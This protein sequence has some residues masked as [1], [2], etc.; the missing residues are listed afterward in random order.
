M[1]IKKGLFIALICQVA[2]GIGLF[3]QTVDANPPQQLILDD[4]VLGVAGPSD[5]F[6][7]SVSVDG[8]VA[9]VG[10]SKTKYMGVVYIYEYIDSTWQ[11]THLIEAPDATPDDLFGAAVK[12]SGD[13]LVV[14]SQRSDLLSSTGSVYVYRHLNGEWVFTQKIKS[15]AP[16]Y[17]AQ[18]GISVET[19]GDWLF[20]GASGAH[21]FTKDTAD[22]GAAY[23]YQWN[24][25]N[26]T[27]QQTIQPSGLEWESFFGVNIKAWNN[28][29]FITATGEDGDMG[30]VYVYD[31][32]A[33]TLAFNQKLEPTTPSGGFFG[34]SMAIDD[35]FLLI[36]APRGQFS[37]GG[38]VYAFTQVGGQ[39][40]L[41][42][43]FS[44]ADT[45][46]SDWFGS[47][48]ALNNGE[49]MVGAYRHESTATDS[50][51]IY[52]FKWQD[53]SWQEFDK[54]SSLT[55]TPTGRFGTAIHLDDQSLLVGG[56]REDVVGERSGAVTTFTQTGG[57]WGD[58]NLL[59][60]TPGNSDA[61]LGQA[62]SHFDQILCAASHQP[63]SND[64][65]KLLCHEW[66]N[67]AWQL[68]FSMILNSQTGAGQSDRLTIDH[69]DQHLLLGAH[70]AGVV[71]VFSKLPDGWQL[72][73]T[74]SSTNPS[75]GDFGRSLAL[76]GD[77]AVI[78]TDR[79]AHVYE[80]DG[81]DWNHVTDLDTGAGNSVSGFGREVRIDNST[82]VVAGTQND[83]DTPS[84]QSVFI[85][86]LIDSTWQ[87]TQSI[88]KQLDAATLVD[89]AASIDLAGNTLAIGS[90]PNQIGS[91]STG[92]VFVFTRDPN[93]TLQTTLKPH[94]GQARHQ[95]GSHIKITDDRVLVGSP[96][97][98][99]L[100]QYLPESKVSVFARDKAQN[101]TRVLDLKTDLVN[102]YSLFG[103]TI[104]G[105]N[106]ALFVGAPHAKNQGAW[107]GAIVH[108]DLTDIDTIFSDD[109][110]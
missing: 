47:A 23:A 16:I 34:V 86:E 87:L 52:H 13:T 104:D 27:L 54:I 50:G 105:H 37:W 6:G 110:D 10:A 73:T 74:L 92:S 35:E 46:G 101:W 108:I 57:F 12:L 8:Q 56:Y 93:W 68:Q 22:V 60:V 95:F 100:G 15:P 28:Q 24:G 61:K 26:Y 40:Q 25:N 51:A 7:I 20:V 99:D 21:D 18:F 1:K 38:S 96:S 59:T 71:F 4:E 102:P 77:T 31:L 75:E 70:A 82:I 48:L 9:A 88:S 45:V 36:G 55:N 91:D 98:L 14:G 19:W 76:D 69:N 53:G 11:K 67:E 72:E 62:I 33:D 97:N 5:Q 17:Q 106:Q 49:L 107:S 79:N 2:I 109:F 44:A 84:D 29:V 3:S 81:N 41:A 66:Q 78:G 32:T 42:Q 83:G 63:E 39:W 85:Y 30:R 103:Q 58:P 90:V 89:F 94:L 64:A 80:F 43:Q 65:I